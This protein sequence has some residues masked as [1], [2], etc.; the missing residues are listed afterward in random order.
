MIRQL[1]DHDFL[2]DSLDQV[3][4]ELQ[5]RIQLAAQNDKE[6]LD[7]L[8]EHGI[9]PMDLIAALE[10][11]NAPETRANIAKEEEKAIA[12]PRYAVAGALQT[13]L[14]RFYEER[15][16]ELLQRTEA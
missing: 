3:R 6:T 16:P 11:L 12:M 7:L 2:L 10:A 8:K 9:E 1:L 5:D 15:K 4:K 14:Q 13:R